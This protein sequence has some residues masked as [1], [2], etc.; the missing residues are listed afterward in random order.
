MIQRCAIACMAVA[1]AAIP[2]VALAFPLQVG[3]YQNDNRVIEIQ[4]REG[5]LCFQSFVENRFI[6]ASVARDRDNDNFYRVRET[7]IRLYQEDLDVILAGPLHDLQPYTR[8]T[9]PYAGTINSL[10]QDCLDDDDGRYYEE[11][12]TVG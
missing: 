1:A 10:L 9:D 8:V 5:R 6:T 2:Q 12:E 3:T 11:V 4:V 7:S